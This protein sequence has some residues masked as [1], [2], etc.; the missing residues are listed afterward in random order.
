MSIR[1]C[2]LLLRALRFDNIHDRDGRKLIDN[3]APIRDIFEEF[4]RKCLSN[5]QV[6]ECT[7]VDKM[8]EGFR[9]R[10]KFRQYIRNKPAKYEIKVYALVDARTFYTSNLEIYASKQP[11][12][13]YKLDNSANSVVKQIIDPIANTC[14]LYTSGLLHSKNTTYSGSTYQGRAT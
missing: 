14:L 7:T 10:C 4:V 6:G 1:R 11:E 8:L 9:G 13:V 5:Y 12:G 2:Y 3:L